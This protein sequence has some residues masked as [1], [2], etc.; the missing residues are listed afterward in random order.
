MAESQK[1]DASASKTQKRSSISDDFGKEF[2]SSWKSMSVSEDD[3]LDFNQETVPK[4]KKNAFNFDKL[5]MDFSL[6]GDFGK[7]LSSFNV[8]MPDLDFSSPQK[9]LS[10]PKE[11]GTEECIDGK[12][13][14][15]THFSF[16]FDFNELDSFD[17][18]SSLLKGENKSKKSA[19][20]FGSDSP[21]K[22]DKVQ[23]PTSKPVASMDSAEDSSSHK[24][25][26]S[27]H[28]NTSKFEHLIGDFGKFN[29]ISDSPSTS[30]NF[31]NFSPSHSTEASAEKGIAV[32]AKETDQCSQHLE[33]TVHTE[34]TAQHTVQ[35]ASSQPIYMEEQTAQHAVQDSSSRPIYMEDSVQEAVP[36]IRGEVCCSATEEN[37]NPEEAVD[38]SVKVLNQES[39]P[40]THIPSPKISTN[41][42]ML[43]ENNVQMGDILG[44]E[45]MQS[46]TDIRA[47]SFEN[48]ALKIPHSTGTP[49][50]DKTKSK[51][52]LAPLESEG[53]ARQAMKDK[54]SGSVQSKY[55]K[56]PAETASQQNAVLIPTKISPVS[57]KKTETVL[58]GPADSR[59]QECIARDAQAENQKVGASKLPD[60]AAGK[61]IPVVLG[62][63][64][65]DNNHDISTRFQVHSTSNPVQTTKS[66]APK[67]L[68]SKLV[69]SL[70]PLKNSKSIHVEV[71]RFPSLLSAKKTLEASSLKMSKL[72]KPTDQSNLK[73]QTEMKSLTHSESK[74]AIHSTSPTMDP[75]VSGEKEQ[76][77]SPSLKRKMF[78][79]SN[80]DPGTPYSLK[81]ITSSP[82]GC[83]E[84]QGT[85]ERVANKR[86]R[87][88]DNLHAGYDS[89][90]KLDVLRDECWKD[91]QV[92]LIMETDENIEK[93]EAYAK[94]L[95]DICN[96]LKKKHDEAKE[97][98]V[99]AIV[100]NNNLLMLNHPIYDE[101][102]RM[103]QQFSTLMLSE[104]LQT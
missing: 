93:A 88:T 16:G 4:G 11:K 20:P 79:A 95:E 28:T 90:P 71:N 29:A 14:K 49:K 52:L 46:D 55:F 5:D 30:A 84:A 54:G 45:P 67:S 70:A 60:P 8:D 83:R 32:S 89:S 23:A 62:H 101:K 25:P 74:T 56:K 17:F 94:E 53:K 65:N 38:N 100:N 10:K 68:N 42:K 51:L 22:Q 13:G 75:T 37:T 12:R 39:S 102:I 44:D 78:E 34:Q 99:R 103:V 73:V 50:E 36:D 19:D 40:A 80:A 15:Q 86:V 31:G 9:K 69:S 57:N 64:K 87:S 26:T 27:Q 82:N 41:D 33:M 92:P 104:K 61:G 21:G 43:G 85:S 76:I 24:L 96:M 1:E 18:D 97:L 47:S 35:N 63:G 77:I 91:L 7:K 81:N 72:I 6:D 2:F 58:L 98:L 48:I 59:R 66:N 3:G